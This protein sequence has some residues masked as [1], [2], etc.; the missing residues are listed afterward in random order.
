MIRRNCRARPM[1]M[2]SMIATSRWRRLAASLVVSLVAARSLPPS[3]LS[4]TGLISAKSRAASAVEAPQ[5]P[6]PPAPSPRSTSP[7]ETE[8][9]RAHGVVDLAK[10]PTITP[11]GRRRRADTSPATRRTLHQLAQQLPSVRR[12]RCESEF[13]RRRRAPNAWQAVRRLKFHTSRWWMAHDGHRHRCGLRD[14]RNHQR[15]AVYSPA[16]GATLGGPYSAQSFFASVY[17][18]GSLV[19]P[20][21]YYD[22]MAKRWIVAYLESA[23]ALMQLSGCRGQPDQLAD[24][25]VQRLPVPPPTSDRTFPTTSVT[26]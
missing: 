1:T 7:A 16:T 17:H 4:R 5:P 10:L 6:Q 12:D 23:G 8:P 15:L 13:R 19:D 11:Q 14:A 25:A 26:A 20:Q 24:A 3:R 22:V 21:M 9:S 2:P 18:G